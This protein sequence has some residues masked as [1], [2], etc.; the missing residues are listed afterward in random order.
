VA[1]AWLPGEDSMSALSPIS[2]PA[3]V[4]RTQSH[5]TVRRS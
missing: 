4:T 5:G 3:T 1:P 2:T